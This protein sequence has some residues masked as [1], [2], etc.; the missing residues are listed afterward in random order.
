MGLRNFLGKLPPWQKQ[1]ILGTA[2]K[3]WF[4]CQRFHFSGK[5]VYQDLCRKIQ[6]ILSPRFHSS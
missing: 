6:K 4:L 5:R 1:M 3:V 2:D